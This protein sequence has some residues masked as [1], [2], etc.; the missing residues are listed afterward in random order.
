MQEKVAEAV[1]MTTLTADERETLRLW[2][3]ALVP[4][5]NRQEGQA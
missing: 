2:Q 5:A 3:E 1:A 4:A